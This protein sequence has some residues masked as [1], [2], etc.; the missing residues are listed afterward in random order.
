MTFRDSRVSRSQGTAARTRL[1][2]PEATVRSADALI[3]LFLAAHSIVL[4]MFNFQM[5]YEYQINR[6]NYC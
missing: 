2:L 4:E 5:K 3:V 6:T 1:A